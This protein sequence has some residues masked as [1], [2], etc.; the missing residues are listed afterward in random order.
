M[1]QALTGS[2][3]VGEIL[4]VSHTWSYYAVL[5][6]LFDD[7]HNLNLCCI[8]GN[9]KGTWCTTTRFMEALIIPA[10]PYNYT[11][12]K[13]HDLKTNLIQLQIQGLL[14]TVMVMAAKR[15]SCSRKIF[16]EILQKMSNLWMIYLSTSA[17]FVNSLFW[18]RKLNWITTFN[19]LQLNWIVDAKRK[20]LRK[21]KLKKKS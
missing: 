4:L 7:T 21:L 5:W 18:I 19:W 2:C 8:Y 12:L 3:Q 10:V 20:P 6:N 13:F 11:S 9:V 14:I 15:A 1:W 17:P 16:G